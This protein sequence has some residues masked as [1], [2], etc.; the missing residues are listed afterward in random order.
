MPIRRCPS[1]DRSQLKGGHARFHGGHATLGSEFPNPPA[2]SWRCPTARLRR[3][4]RVTLVGGLFGCVAQGALDLQILV[5]AELAPLSTVAT[6]LVATERRVHVEGM[7]DR[8]PA[9]PDLAGHGA[10][11][12]EVGS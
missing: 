11:L 1:V 2:S 9:G 3:I 12:V 4:D 7:V 8:H 5:E 10:G 6:A